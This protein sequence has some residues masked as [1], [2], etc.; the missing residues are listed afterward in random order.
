[1]INTIR[2]IAVVLI[3]C[4]VLAA[5]CSTAT[6]PDIQPTSFLWKV[7]SDV[8]TVYILGS[9]HIARAGLY[10]LDEVI[11][12]AYDRSENLVVEIIEGFLID[13]DVHFVVVGAAHLVGENGII[14][15]LDKKGYKV[16]QL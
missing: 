2:S 6:E 3:L 12:D 7:S 4:L 13:N 1:M 5:S 11:E 15:L 10:P 9:V 14:N 8:N 16:S